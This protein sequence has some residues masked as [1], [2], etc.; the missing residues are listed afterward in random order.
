MQLSRRTDYALRALFT[1]VEHRNGRPVAIAQIAIRNEIPKRFLEQIMLELKR[2]GWVDSL[3]GR[4][5]GY[6]LKNC[7]SEIRIG[8][9]IRHF[10]GALAPVGCVSATDYRPC[11]QE[12]RCRFRWLLLQVRNVVNGVIDSFSLEDVWRGASICEAELHEGMHGE[13]I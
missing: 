4:R 9:G 7:P 1:L 2:C 5:G 8:D 10:N 12:A 6:F 3:P 13:G 11:S